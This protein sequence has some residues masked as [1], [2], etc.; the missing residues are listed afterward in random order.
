VHRGNLT[1]AN[2]ARDVPPRR[3]RAPSSD[4]TA[5]FFVCDGSGAPSSQVRSRTSS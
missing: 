1:D 4:R 3:K 2:G 5:L